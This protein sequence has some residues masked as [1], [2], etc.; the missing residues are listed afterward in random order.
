MC[1]MQHTF[2]IR[3]QQRKT[4]PIQE[5]ISQ[6]SELGDNKSNKKGVM[7]NFVN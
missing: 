4:E 2:Q 7:I 5:P 3:K 1:L 6:Q